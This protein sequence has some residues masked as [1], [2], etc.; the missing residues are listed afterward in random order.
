MSSRWPMRDGRPLKNQTCEQGLASSMWPRR[1]RRTL[2]ER[3]FDAA[4]VADDAAVLHA[5]VLAAQALPVGDGSEDAGAEQAIAFG[6]ERAVVDRLRLGDLTVRPRANLLGRREL[7]LD[8]VKVRNRTGC[9]KG[10]G[11]EHILSLR[12]SLAQ[13]LAR[14]QLCE[15][16]FNFKSRC[17]ELR[18]CFDF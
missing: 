6:L 4:L 9:F 17:C 12:N 7:D 2:R 11:A 5:L 14:C 18:C 16:L 10:A 15:S 3:D 13:C 1:S 8:R